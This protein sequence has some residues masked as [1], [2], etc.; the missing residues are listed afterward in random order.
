VEI[1][2]HIQAYDYDRKPARFLH[3]GS[4]KDGNIFACIVPTM[5]NEVVPYLALSYCWGGD[6]RHKTTKRSMLHSNGAVNVSLLPATI[7]DAISV[8]INLGYKYLWVDSLCIIQDD[9][10]DRMAEIAKMPTIYSNAICTIAASFPAKAS[11]GFLGDRTR[12]TDHVMVLRVRKAGEKEDRGISSVHAYP[13]EE[14]GC[15]IQEPL[16]ERGWCVYS[17]SQF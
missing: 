16:A 5:N 14:R 8:T 2:A 9:Q 13:I 3:V 10:Q 11:E 15:F 7:R 6:Q 12:Y 17:N 1:H 4:T